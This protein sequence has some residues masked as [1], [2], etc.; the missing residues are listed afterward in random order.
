MSC[1]Y[2][3]MSAARHDKIGHRAAAGRA[4]ASPW[5]YGDKINAMHLFY[6]SMRRLA[7]KIPPA[8]TRVLTKPLSKGKIK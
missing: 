4:R 8:C 3:I 6:H 5:P 1:I 2:F 7:R